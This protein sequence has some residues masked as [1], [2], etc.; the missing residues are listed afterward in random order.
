MESSA[1]F[2]TTVH[3]ARRCEVAVRSTGFNKTWA[4]I[5]VAFPG[6]QIYEKNRRFLL[7]KRIRSTP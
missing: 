2:G 1:A 3:G 6:V 7:S 4:V 5:R